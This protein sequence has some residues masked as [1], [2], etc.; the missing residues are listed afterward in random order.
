MGG[1]VLVLMQFPSVTILPWLEYSQ[2]NLLN[3]YS[4][5]LWSSKQFNHLSQTLFH[6]FLKL[7]LYNN[8]HKTCCSVRPPPD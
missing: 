7:T 1:K 3:S 6:A 5:S 4:Y 8:S 2:F